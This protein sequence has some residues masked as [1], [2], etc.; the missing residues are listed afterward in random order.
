M[1][2]G[3][4]ETAFDLTSDVVRS[5]LCLAFQ[6]IPREAGPGG[7]RGSLSFSGG[8]GGGGGGVMVQKTIIFLYADSPARTAELSLPSFLLF[9]ISHRV[10]KPTPLSSRIAA[11]ARG[12]E[13]RFQSAA[14]AWP[15]LFIGTFVEITPH[16]P[17]WEHQP[18]RSLA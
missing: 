16:V 5:T 4:I 15:C 12:G 3:Q 2:F 8:G 18:A 1:E 13:F 11:R 14:I 9:F 10:A 6:P 7:R 17:P